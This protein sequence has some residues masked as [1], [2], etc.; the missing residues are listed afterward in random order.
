METKVIKYESYHPIVPM[1]LTELYNV[2][3]IV[4]FFTYYYFAL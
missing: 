3:L 4:S 2:L 1:Q